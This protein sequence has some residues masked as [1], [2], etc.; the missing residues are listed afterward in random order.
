MS[1]IAQT[2]LAEASSIAIDLNFANQKYYPS[3]A[4]DNSISSPAVDLDLSNNTVRYGGGSLSTYLSNSCASGGYVTNADGTLTWAAADTLRIGDGTGLLVEESRINILYPSVPDHAG[5][6]TE[7]RGAVA[8]NSTTAPDGTSTASKFTEDSTASNNHYIQRSLITITANT[9]YTASCFIK[10]G[11]GTARRYTRLSVWDDNTGN[12]VFWAELDL[13]TGTISSTGTHGTGTYTSSSVTALANGWYYLTVT[14]KVDASSTSADFC[15]FLVDVSGSVSYS[16]DGTGSQY[17]WGAQLELG[18]FATSYVPTTTASAT[19]NAD[20]VTASG[21]LASSLNGASAASLFVQTNGMSIISNSDIPV[22]LWRDHNYL[23]GTNGYSSPSTA[24]ILTGTANI[25]T[26]I[27]SGTFAGTTRWVLGYDGTTASLVGN[28]GTVG[29]DAYT[30]SNLS[31]TIQFGGFYTNTNQM[32]GGYIQRIAVWSTR[33]SDTLLQYLSSKEMTAGDLWNSNASGGYVQN[34]DGTMTLV[35]ANTLRIGSGKGLLVEESRTNSI[36]NNSMQGVVLPAVDLDLNNNTVRVGGGSLSDYLSNSNASGGYVTNADGTL[37]WVG[38]NTLRVGTGTGLLVEEGRT[39]LYIRS[40]DY[41]ATGTW[42]VANGT[43]TNSY[44]APDGTST[45]FKLLEG[46]GYHNWTITPAVGMGVSASTTYTSSAYVKALNGRRWVIFQINNQDTS[47]ALCVWYDLTNGAVGT[48]GDLIAG[49]TNKSATITSL[50]NGWYRITVTYTTTSGTTAIGHFHADDAADNGD[51]FAT[52]DGTKGYYLWG[53][54]L[55]LGAFA[56]SY[57]PTVASPAARNADAVTATGALN[58][59]LALTTASI[60]AQTYGIVDPSSTYPRIIDWNS[61]FWWYLYHGGSY[62]NVTSDGT[63]DNAA[64]FGSGTWADVARHAISFSGTSFSGASNNGSVATNTISGSYRSGT[65]QIGGNAGGNR[66]LNGY[67]QRLAVWSSRLTDTQLQYL[68]YHGGVLPNIWSSYDPDG[69]TLDV[70]GAGTEDG[71]DYIDVQVSGIGG[72]VGVTTIVFDTIAAAPGD[73]WTE[74]FFLTKLAGSTSGFANFQIGLNFFDSGYGYLSTSSAVIAPLAGALGLN[75]YSK[76]ATAPANT[77][78]VQPLIIFITTNGVAVD[79]TLRIGWPQMELGAFATS[80]IRTTNAAA[81]RNADVV[82]IASTAATLLQTLT[83]SGLVVGSGTA[84]V[85]TTNSTPTYVLLDLDGY[86]NNTPA[87]IHENNPS[88]M[89]TYATSGPALQ[90]PY[91]SGDMDALTRVAFGYSGSGRSIVV[92]DSLV[93][94]DAKPLSAATDTQLGSG[95]GAHQYGGYFQRLALWSTRLPNVALKAL[96]ADP[97]PPAIVDLDLAGGLVR[98]GVP[99][100]SFTDYLTCSNAS[101]GYVTNADGTLTNV[102]PNTLRIGTGTGLLVEESRTNGIRNN[103]MQGASAGTPGVLPTNWFSLNDWNTNGIANDVIGVGVEDGIDYID[104]R[105]HGTGGASFSTAS[106]IGFDYPAATVGQTWSH[107]VYCRMVGGS[108]TNISNIAIGIVEANSGFSFLAE[109]VDTQFTPTSS[110]LRTQRITQTGTTTQ[111]TTAMVE[112]ALGV[113]CPIGVPIDITLRIGWPQL[114]LGNGATS[115]IRTTS[116]TAARSADN[117]SGIGNLL[118]A[119]NGGAATVAIKWKQSNADAVYSALNCLWAARTDDNNRI[120]PLYLDT[121]GSISQRITTSGSLQA[122]SV[123][124]AAIGTNKLVSAWNA[125]GQAASLNGASVITGAIPAGGIPAVSNVDVGC[126]LTFGGANYLNDYIQRL[127]IWNTRLSDLQLQDLTASAVI[128][129]DMSSIPVS[130]KGGTLTSSLSN[131]NASGGYV[132]NADG[133]LTWVG[134]NTLRVGNGTGLLVEESSINYSTDSQ[135]GFNNA[136]YWVLENLG[137]TTDGAITAPDGTTT[138]TLITDNTTNGPH[139]VNKYDS[140]NTGVGNT[141]T[142]S[143]YLKKGTAN[144]ACVTDFGPGG[145]AYCYSVV[146]DLNLGVTGETKVG[147]SA[148]LTSYSIIALANGWYRCSITGVNS[149][150]S[151]GRHWPCI[152]F[153]AAASGNVFNS[154][155][156][157]TYVGSGNTIYIWGVQHEQRNFTTSYIPTTSTAATRN[158]DVVSA[159]GTLLT[160]L[161]GSSTG[162]LSVY[163]QA[164][165]YAT[166]SADGTLIM[167]PT[168][169]AIT[170]G[171][172]DGGSLS[173]GLNSVS[174]LAQTTNL[175]QG[176]TQKISAA[177]MVN[178]NAVVLNGG[179]VATN[180]NATT[181][182]AG[183][184]YYIGI[185]NSGS[186]AFN[187]YVARLAIWNLRLSNAKLQALTA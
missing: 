30:I 136:T 89:F 80:P 134:A 33:L 145:G 23:F 73:I 27:G 13:Q 20:V 38:A 26:H 107:S 28:N 104:I 182:I 75:R 178:S 70:I 153:A 52:G 54:Q 71:I 183:T 133:T 47:A 110:P 68:S 81:T 96:T 181:P 163:I 59:N 154:L 135:N 82:S 171:D 90:V 143:V 161:K 72:S 140:L 69:L 128:D 92:N 121:A 93:T 43:L 115:P 102:A 25:G 51:R 11:T 15:L 31:G 17:W 101:G 177:F 5:T 4:I 61:Q 131:S 112:G 95:G 168:T 6:W 114:E 129:L 158:A 137:T 149:H 180:S 106:D 65:A 157:P 152:G 108:L 132:T 24:M 111:A 176:I 41:T 120:I 124:T 79:I 100:S 119:L 64:T 29:S 169:G 84:A 88:Y 19:R 76:T 166:Q 87:Y 165:R 60:F 2:L 77:A 155:Q 185:S 130:V 66:I 39:N 172:Q 148:T 45:A 53:D 156:Q 179:T 10:A 32:I 36:T 37:T 21:T 109:P 7:Q 8:V 12:N 78:Y 170:L 103:S 91:G 22:V 122:I 118:S 16:G 160:L 159:S 150:P 56:T 173:E 42:T 14:G 34:A 141:T 62:Q 151:D 164:L 40:Q 174:Y 113:H 9:T 35:P 85:Q 184:A 186:A 83:F 146:F 139:D 46:T 48:I 99:A 125:A 50:A 67:I 18:S 58:T 1:S 162:P 3:G 142:L 138:A 63:T 116:G 86:N 127:A 126:Y 187:G 105:W 49:F 97:P 98:A 57:I 123:G 94:T 44:A 147:A 144:Y 55:E 167:S 74:S 175:T 117:I